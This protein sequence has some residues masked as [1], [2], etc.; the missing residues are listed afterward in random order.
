MECPSCERENPRASRFCLGCGTSLARRCSGCGRELPPDAAFCDDCGRPVTQAEAPRSEFAPAAAAEAPRSFASGRYQVRR[1]LGEGAKKR[2][3]LA[4]DSMLDREVA[5]GLLKT[6]GLDEGGLARVRREAQ[7]TGRLGDHPHMVTVFDVAQDG[8]QIFIVSQFMAGGDVEARIG[9]A[10][11][12][13][14]AVDEALRITEQV[15]RALEH[16]HGQGIIHRDVKPGNVWLAE[17]GTAR[18]GDFGLA[19]AADRTRLTEEGMIV[20]TPAYMPPEQAV[21]GEV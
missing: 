3:Y 7:A 16:G 9:E 2:V 5:I 20:G 1:F 18:L 14:L 15:C 6:E 4:R 17:D 10:P 19:L 13:R 21:G 12:H 11:E 8:A